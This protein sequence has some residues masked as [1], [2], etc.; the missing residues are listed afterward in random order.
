MAAT[1][2]A[3]LVRNTDATELQQIYQAQDPDDRRDLF[4]DRRRVD[5]FPGSQAM[6]ASTLQV[7]TWSPQRLDIDD[8]DTYYLVLTHRRQT[9][10]RTM[11]GYETERYA[12][13]V[14]LD[15]EGQERLDLFTILEQRLQPELRA[16]VR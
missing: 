6:A 1:L 3:D 5:L 12:L 14:E 15:A 7:R 13:A 4:N 8:G 11:A 2:R 16:R 9:W 10:A